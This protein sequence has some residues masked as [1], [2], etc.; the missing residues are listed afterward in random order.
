MTKERFHPVFTRV[1]ARSFA[2]LGAEDRL[3]ETMHAAMADP[4]EAADLAESGRE[5]PHRLADFLDAGGAEG[6]TIA[7][8]TASQWVT[9]QT[10]SQHAMEEVASWEPRLAIWM[11][12]FVSQYLLDEFSRD[13]F[14]DKYG[15]STS[16]AI[17]YRWFTTGGSNS[18]EV[19]KESDYLDRK[20]N[21]RGV[22]NI[23]RIYVM[24][25]D[26]RRNDDLL[27]AV[28]DSF[29]CLKEMLKAPPEVIDPG[30]LQLVML[31]TVYPLQILVMD[32][33]TAEHPARL[34]RKTLPA[35]TYAVRE[36]LGSMVDTTEGRR[37]L[38][39]LYA[40]AILRYPR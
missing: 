38:L 34:A 2:A 8:V 14:K 25:N 13:G 22:S 19:A 10:T 21:P 17:G 12:L 23:P 29:Y 5:L 18:A 30:I 16:I 37:A 31:G 35:P 20:A 9:R 11:A 6:A 39:P 24:N 3:S 1:Y 4:L 40:E 26:D 36:W 28:N 32:L 15:L 27:S 33:Q 7:L